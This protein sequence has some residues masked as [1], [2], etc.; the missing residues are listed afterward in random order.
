MKKLAS[1]LALGLLFNLGQAQ[2]MDSSWS[3]WDQDENVEAFDDIRFTNTLIRDENEFHKL[4]DSIHLLGV[5]YR[6]IEFDSNDNAFNTLVIA[7]GYGIER[8][9]VGRWEEEQFSLVNREGKII[10]MIYLDPEL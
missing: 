9:K 5:K 8:I 6:F 3:I 1:V 2:F 10:Q 4:R 7:D